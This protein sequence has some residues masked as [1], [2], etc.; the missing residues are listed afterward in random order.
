VNG[1]IRLFTD[2]TIDPG[3]VL[4]VETGPGEGAVASVREGKVRVEED[5]TEFLPGYTLVLPPTDEHRV[6]PLRA[7]EPTRL[8]RVVH[9]TGH[10]FVTGAPLAR[11]RA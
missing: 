6:I 2:S 10:G 9:G 1:D 8:I 5:G 11:R 4:T 7:E 3:A